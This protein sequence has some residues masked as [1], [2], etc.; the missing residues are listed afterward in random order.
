MLL[1][2]DPFCVAA[3][4]DWDVVPPGDYNSHQAGAK[5]I[6]STFLDKTLLG[7]ITG[8]ISS[9]V[10]KTVSHVTRAMGQST[11]VR[12]GFRTVSQ[13]TRAMG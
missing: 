1:K 6:S 5:A 2:L 8:T 4:D 13:V 9:Q 7:S 3:L 12:E 11:V 10:G